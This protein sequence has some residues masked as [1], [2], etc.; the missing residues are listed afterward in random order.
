MFYAL[1]HGT[2]NNR[3]LSCNV[4][5]I[6]L[7]LHHLNSN[8]CTY[9]GES[10]PKNECYPPAPIWI[11]TKDPS[12]SKM[13]PHM[14]VE[15]EAIGREYGHQADRQVMEGDGREGGRGEVVEGRVRWWRGG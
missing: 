13:Q 12:P 9:I 8:C 6:H 10:L 15:S 4:F 2:A 1:T 3:T 14:Q 7:Q 11:E 5:G